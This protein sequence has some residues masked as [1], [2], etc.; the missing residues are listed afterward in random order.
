MKGLI[1]EYREELAAERIKVMFARAYI[2]ALHNRICS[3]PSPLETPIEIIISFLSE[4]IEYLE[5][6]KAG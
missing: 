6:K 3:H 5:T 4:A 1:D 2:K